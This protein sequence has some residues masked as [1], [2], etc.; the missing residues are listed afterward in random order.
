M[1]GVFFAKEKKGLFLDQVVFRVE[2]RG[3]AGKGR[4]FICAGFIL[5]AFIRKFHIDWFKMP[6]LGEAET[7]V[8]SVTKFWFGVLAKQK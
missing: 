8:R 4:G 2:G 6:L 5:L 1:T 7:A 3:G